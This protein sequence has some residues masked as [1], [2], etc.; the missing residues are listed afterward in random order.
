KQSV[1]TLLNQVEIL[2]EIASSFS[3]FAR[4][5]APILEK[6]DLVALLNKTVNLYSTY[7]GGKVDFGYDKTTALINGD[8]QLLDRIFS[9]LILNGLQ[10][11]G[12]PPRVKVELRHVETSVQIVVQDNGGGIPT[13]I[14]DKI[15]IPYFT[16]KKSGSGLGLAIARQGIELSG[17]KIWFESEPGN[18]KFYVEFLVL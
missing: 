17:G 1:T 10:A 6:L 4:M 16:T 7:E 13:D 3:A 11:G 14:Q 15:F 12:I 8:P 18:T 5:P 2:N 9:N